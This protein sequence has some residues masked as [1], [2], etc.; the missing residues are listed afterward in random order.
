M[1]YQQRY[2]EISMKPWK[3]DAEKLQ[4]TQCVIE[5]QMLTFL[6]RDWIRNEEIWPEINYK[7]VRIIALN[8]I[9]K[10]Q[11][12]LNIYLTTGGLVLDELL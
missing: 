9:N 2:T 3:T 7:E 12:T 6:P 5:K 4:S 10:V 1:L 11:D 8:M